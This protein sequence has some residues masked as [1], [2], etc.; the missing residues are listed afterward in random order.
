MYYLYFFSIFSCYQ[1]R[2]VD[3]FLH[4]CSNSNN[5]KNF[6]INHSFLGNYKLDYIVSVIFISF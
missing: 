1:S 2:T 3:N 6:Q 5:P 4:T